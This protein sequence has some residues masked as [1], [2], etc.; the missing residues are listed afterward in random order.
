MSVIEKMAEIAER[1]GAS[2]SANAEK[3]CRIKERAID[4]YAC[5]C[6]P[7]DVYHFCMSP[8]CRAE[9]DA[10]GRCHCGLFVKEIKKD[11][12]DVRP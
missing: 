2:L 11:D 1:N 7:D 5:P 4:E 12:D 6:Y 8:L 3:I 10:K 9:L